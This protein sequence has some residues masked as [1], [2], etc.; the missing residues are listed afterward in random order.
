M[1]TKTQ[2][3]FSRTLVGSFTYVRYAIR[4]ALI[5]TL[6][7]ALVSVIAD[8]IR[9]HP[10]VEGYG[11]G[12]AFCLVTSL[13][14]SWL[15]MA[16]REGLGVPNP[17]IGL[18]VGR[19]EIALG[20]SLLGFLFAVGLILFLAGF[21]VFLIIMMIA[22]IGGGA[23]SGGDVANAPI[24]ET[25]EAF[26]AFLRETSTGRTVATIGSGV[27]LIAV[28]F[29][30]WFI[31]RLS[32]FAA[33]AI[34]Q[35]RFVVFQAMAWTRYTDRPLMMSGLLV[36]GGAVILILAGRFAISLL[37]V[38]GAIQIV[39]AHIITCFSVLLIVGFI[40]EI[41]RQV[42]TESSPSSQVPQQT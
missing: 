35:R 28:L 22:A 21:L 36:V 11:L 29:M 30:S 7:F 2:L 38:P 31:L 42:V 32:P 27:L 10:I 1:S 33:G 12:I 41:Y 20:A 24:F 3:S 37:P 25:P 39:L 9:S 17:R 14:V 34:A 6:I 4:P 18:G 8:F 26:R 13:G 40:C 23:L 5:G 15:A 19:Q 16:L